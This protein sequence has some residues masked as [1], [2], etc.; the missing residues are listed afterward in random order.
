MGFYS[1]C[2]EFLMSVLCVGVEFEI[3]M[4]G[5]NAGILSLNILDLA[6]TGEKKNLNMFCVCL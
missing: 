3:P 4:Y 6:S 5:V 2:V 1:L